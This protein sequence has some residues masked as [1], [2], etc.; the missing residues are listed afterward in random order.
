MFAEAIDTLDKFG[1]L[2]ALIVLGWWAFLLL[3]LARS[4]RDDDDKKR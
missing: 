3:W 4:F 2:L 1:P